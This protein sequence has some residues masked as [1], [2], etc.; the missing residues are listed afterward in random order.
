[1]LIAA[2]IF[3]VIAIV[4]L[5]YIYTGSNP[6]LLLLAKLIFYFFLVLFFVLLI[7]DLLSQAPP[8]PDVDSKRP[9]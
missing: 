3:L 9:I 8:I 5:I 6:T 1:M 2:F 7:T 4:G